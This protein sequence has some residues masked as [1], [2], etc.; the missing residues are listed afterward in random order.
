MH[1]NMAAVCWCW[2]G[3]WVVVVGGGGGLTGCRR[4]CVVLVAVLGD[5][6]WMERSSRDGAWGFRRTQWRWNK[7][8]RV[9]GCRVAHG[10]RAGGEI[11]SKRASQ[12]GLDAAS[13]GTGFGVSSRSAAPGP[14]VGGNPAN[15]LPPPPPPRP[16]CALTEASCL[17]AMLHAVSKPSAMRTGCRPLCSRCSACSSRAP[18][19]T[20]TPVVPSPISSSWEADSS[21]MRRAIW[22]S[23]CILARMVAPSLEMVTSPSGDTSILSMPA[24]TLM[25]GTRPWRQNSSPSPSPP[26]SLPLPVSCACG[27]LT[28]GAQGGAQDVGHRARSQDVSLQRA[29]VAA[30]G[31]RGGGQ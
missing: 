29:T 28:L 17:T 2:V 30:T 3:G 10:G 11:E 31:R 25:R 24:R 5:V 20:T 16:S 14:A 18:A 26:I 22:C 27:C 4:P 8:V 13:A 12:G 7:R 21:T 19:S 1:G 23:T 6:L 15:L 9:T